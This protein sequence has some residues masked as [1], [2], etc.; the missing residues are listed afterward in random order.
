MSR[1]IA[2]GDIHGCAGALDT[3]LEEIQPRPTDTIVTL[4]DYVDRG[5]ESSRVIEILV[6]LVSHCRLVPLIGNHE[7]MMFKAIIDPDQMEFW[8]QFGGNTTLALSL[9]HISE[10]TRPY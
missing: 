8:L 6:G 5:P 1:T 9:I 4:G 3:L 10:P 7:I 2:I